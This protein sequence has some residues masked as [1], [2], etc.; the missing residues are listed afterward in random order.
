MDYISPT[1]KRILI[2]RQNVNVSQPEYFGIAEF[3]KNAHDPSSN[4]YSILD[5]LENLRTLL[6]KAY[7]HFA[8]CY[9]DY[10]NCWE[11][12]QTGN[13]IATPALPPTGTDLNKSPLH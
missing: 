13:P 5:Q 8:L 10:F 3:S 2:A 12:R 6:G 4:S 9:D 7:F 11:W 1:A